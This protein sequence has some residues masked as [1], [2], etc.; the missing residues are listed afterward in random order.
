[1]F[2]N[3]DF[4]AEKNLQHYDLCHPRAASSVATLL[5]KNSNELRL[6]NRHHEESH[7]DSVLGEVILT[8]LYCAS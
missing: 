7:K 6:V 5:K 2:K 4:S 8:S 3:H 1:M